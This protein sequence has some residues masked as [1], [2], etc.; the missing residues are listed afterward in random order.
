MLIIAFPVENRN[1]EEQKKFAT[2]SKDNCEEHSTS[3]LAKN[4]NVPIRQEDYI[5]QVSKVIEVRVTKKLYQEVSATKKRILGAA[6]PLD[7]FLMNPLV[8]G[9]SGAAPET[10]LNAYGTK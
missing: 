3:N 9:Y 7:D 1:P 5:T 4:S 8:Q 10:S 6:S 2:L